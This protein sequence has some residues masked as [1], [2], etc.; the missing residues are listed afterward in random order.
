MTF[1][2]PFRDV[3][4][5][6]D[7][8]DKTK[9]LVLGTPHLRFMEE[10]FRPEL[11]DNLIVR[12][13]QFA[14]QLI[15][16]ERMPPFLVAAMEQEGGFYATILELFAAERLELGHHAQEQLSLNRTEAERQAAAYST[17][18]KLGS[19]ERIR[20][21]LCFLAAYDLYAALLQ[22]S[23]LPPQVRADSGLP[24][25]IT[26]ELERQIDL[27]DE[28]HSLALR[29]A[30]ELGHETLAYIDDHQD[31]A[32]YFGIAE[33]LGA[34][35][36]AS[37][38]KVL[39]KQYSSGKASD[40]AFEAAVARGDLLPYYRFANSPEFARQSVN[41]ECGIYLRTK[42]AS[43]LDRARLAQWEVRNL[44]MAA[45]IRCASALC[46]GG[47]LLVLVGSSHK[48]LLE[49]YLSQLIDIEMVSFAKLCTG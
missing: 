22:W 21:V 29:L 28:R 11:L 12:L 17:A 14:P 42:L 32:I 49:H 1:D 35:L 37:N 15:A 3:Q 48:P 7:E 46:P 23:A 8:V 39:I 31:A 18:S 26:A 38:F 2:M 6:A 30:R 24:V 19:A 44:N 45:R 25:R 20:L 13:K 40:R 43:G 47:R 4:A 34:E 41:R 16:T 9:I 5:L 10:R 33:Q 36:E 27:P